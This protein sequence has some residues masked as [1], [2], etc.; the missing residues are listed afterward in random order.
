M[1]GQT[2]DERLTE[3]A[4]QSK[5]SRVA[6]DDLLVQTLPLIKRIAVRFAKQFDRSLD[7][8]IVQDFALVFN[9]YVIRY[10]PERGQCWR[11]FIIARF[12]WFCQD[13]VRKKV[14]A[15]ICQFTSRSGA[16]Q[17]NCL[18]MS[19]AYHAHAENP[20]TL[21]DSIPDRSRDEFQERRDFN[22]RI[23]ALEPRDRVI[24]NAYYVDGLSMKEI[25]EALNLSE[26]RVSQLHSSA[27]VR[28]R[29]IAKVQTT[30]R[31]KT[32]VAA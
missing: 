17:M 22:E 7:D 32:A 25:G 9:R 3:L 10:S 28:L 2:T 15:R 21:G 6:R 5:T 4:V 11:V 1:D 16:V 18:S 29:Q 23:K 12:N 24:M 13:C 30:K 14:N 26:S 19:Y 31:K 20:E 8:D 27:I